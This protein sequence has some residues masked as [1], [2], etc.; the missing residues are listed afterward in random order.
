LH[1][2]GDNGGLTGGMMILLDFNVPA[3]VQY[4]LFHAGLERR[5]DCNEIVL[6]EFLRSK[7]L[8]TWQANKKIGL[9]HS[10]E[11]SA[12]GACQLSNVAAMQ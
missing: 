10:C 2:P 5:Q 11:L 1:F 4:E 3:R 8:C 7:Y 12:I 9:C 6:T